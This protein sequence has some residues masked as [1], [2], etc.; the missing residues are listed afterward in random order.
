[1]RIRMIFFGVLALVVALALA[2]Y[3][4]LRN[5]NL[6]D[7]KDVIAAEVKEI[8]SRDLDIRGHITFSI[9]LKPTITARDLA[10]ANASWAGEQDLLGID[11]LDI[12][13]DLI[14]LLFG[15]FDTTELAFKGGKL[16]LERSASGQGNWQLGLDQEDVRRT[17]EYLQG[18]FPYVHGIRLEDIDV[19]YADQRLGTKLSGHIKAFDAVLEPKGQRLTTNLDVEVKN[20]TISASGTVTKLLSLHAGGT[21]SVALSIELD[22][23]SL[24]LDGTVDTEHGA[25]A[26]DGTFEAASPD[27]RDL[28]ALA[29]VTLPDLG[30]FK[31]SGKISLTPTALDLTTLEAR[32]GDSDLRGQ[33]KVGLGQQPSFT[34]DLS[35]NRID[36]TPFIQAWESDDAAPVEETAENDLLFSDQPL[37]F[38][39]L[40]SMEADVKLAVDKLTVGDLTLDAALLQVKQSNRDLKIDPFKVDYKGATFTGRGEVSAAEPQRVTLKVLTQNF[41]LGSFL[42]QQKVTDLVEGEIDIG[43]DVQGQGNSLHAIVGTLDGKASFVMSKGRIASRD[44]DLIAAGLLQSLMP[45]KKG[46][47]ETS[48]KC[49]LGQFEIKKGL[50]KTQSL[51]FD[52]LQMTMTGK[53][54]IDLKT[55]AVDLKLL[56][57]PKDPTLISLAT[58]LRVTGTLLD[59]KVSLDPESLLKEVAEA[60]AGVWLLGPAGIL[61]P[62]ASLGAGHHHPCVN[63]LQKVFGTKVAK[64]LGDSKAPASPSD[65]PDDST[66]QPLPIPTEVLIS[67]AG[68]QITSNVMRRHLTDLGFSNITKVEKQGA[69]FHVG[70]DW[71]SRSLKLRIDARLGTIE[72]SER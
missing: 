50:A 51:L 49:A 42:A 61:I 26:F 58:G 38:D 1:M 29:G 64:Q 2:G 28:A 44:V 17:E 7:Y 47:K 70:A 18:P 41:D 37:F 56:P 32:V 12:T 19:D 60:A 66:S 22:Q 27:P 39:A 31:A 34:V 33:A 54:T 71:Q 40:P 57:R 4:V 69:I 65:G 67:L 14:G 63:D 5:L 48:I 21:S 30:A 43:I 25:N 9:S 10:L 68:D 8:T 16:S 23:T 45:W 53:G 11:Q 59:T 13:L 35:S 3:L 15:T 36:M 20:Q 72:H 6:D 24:T 55:E 52:T 62:Y 46:I